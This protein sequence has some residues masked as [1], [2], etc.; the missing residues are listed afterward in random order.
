MGRRVRK[1]TRQRGQDR[2]LEL[3]ITAPRPHDCRPPDPMADVRART[4]ADGALIDAYQITNATL[5]TVAILDACDT[6]FHPLRRLDAFIEPA[7]LSTITRIPQLR[8]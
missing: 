6:G 3:P 8:S 2:S 1:D 4:L 7:G 5:E